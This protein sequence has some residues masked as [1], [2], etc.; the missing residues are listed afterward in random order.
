MH[1]EKRDG[2]RAI[3]LSSRREFLKLCSAV[4]SVLG[5]G[6]TGKPQV[7]KALTTGSKPPALWLHFAEY[8]GCTESFLRT[9]D[10]YVDELL[11]DILSVD[12]RETIMAG[13]GD[14]VRRIL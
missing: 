1:N 13:A 8:T 12:Y 11:L 3:T 4:A 9:I 7:A 10:P 2:T 14:A 6:A 5:L